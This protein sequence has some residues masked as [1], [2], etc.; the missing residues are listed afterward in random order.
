MPSKITSGHKSVKYELVDKTNSRML[1]AVGLATFVVFFSIFAVRAL[2]VQSSYNRQVIEKKELAL[3]QLVENKKIVDQLEASYI[4]FNNQPTN[5]LGGSPT[6]EG[7]KDGSNSKLILDAL[8]GEYD[9]PALSSSFE[10]IL[11]EGGYDVDSIG[12]SEDAALV[13]SN[14][15]TGQAQPIQVAYAFSVSADLSGTKRL[16]ET[17]ESSIRPMH[18]DKLDIQVSSGLLQTGIA[19][20]TYFTQPK[21][22]QLTSEV[23][24]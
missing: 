4:S 12:G 11:R 16:L 8:P 5:V 1:T 18:V 7:P 9:Y 10:K 23:V 14:T 2:L 19:L 24:K 6:G 17:L 13:A 22:F 20:H 21:T 3:R 15:P